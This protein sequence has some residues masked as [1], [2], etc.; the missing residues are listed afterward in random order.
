MIFQHLLHAKSPDVIAMWAKR[1]VD[2]LNKR[3]AKD[4]PIGSMIFWPMPDPPLG[5]LACDGATVNTSDYR[6]LFIALGNTTGDTFDVPNVTSP[7][8][9]QIIIRAL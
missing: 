2:D 7:I 6:E 9:E 5:W 4:P 1:L 8:T 3:V